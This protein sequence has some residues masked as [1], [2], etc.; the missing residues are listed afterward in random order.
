MDK[1]K[2]KIESGFGHIAGI[3]FDRS[4]WFLF[5][6]LILFAGLASGIQYTRLDTSTEGFLH[7]N[8]PVR[9]A[10]DA[11]K[12]QF[13]QDDRILV[14]IETED[15]FKPAFLSRLQQLHQRLEEQVPYLESVDS[16]ISSRI[17]TGDDESLMVEELFDPWP[18]HSHQFDRLKQLALDNPLLSNLVIN[19][20]STFTTILIQTQSYQE[21]EKSESSALDDL[22]SVTDDPITT[23]TDLIAA[24]EPISDLQKSII[25]DKIKE[26]VSHFE[27]DNFH[28]YVA[29]SPEVTDSLQSMMAKEMVLFVSLVIVIITLSLTIL[30]RR[31]VGVLLPLLTV[32]LAVVGTMGLMGHSSTP[33]QTVTQILPSFL[34][35]VGVGAAI[36]ILAIFFKVFDKSDGSRQDKRNALVYTL[37]HSGLAIAITSLTTAAGLISF[38]S[39][40][41]SAVS[42]LGIFASM[43]VLILLAFVLILIPALISLL[44]IRN[45]KSKTDDNPMSTDWIER[46]LLGISLFSVNYFRT[47][48][49]GTALLAL[50]GIAATSQISYSHNPLTWLPSD[51]SGRIATEVVD[52]QMQGSI[53]M[54]LII[55][56]GIENGMIQPDNLKA[57][58]DLAN[59]AMS[60]RGETYS[61]GKTVSIANVVKEIHQALNENDP[62][63]YIIPTDAKLIAQEVLLFENSGSDDLG[64]LV[65]S[66][67]SL[68][69]MTIKTP[70]VDAMEYDD[71]ITKLT[72]KGKSLFGENVTISA[73]GMIPML[74]KTTTSA[75]NS[76]GISYIIAFGAIASMMMVMLGSFRLGLISMIPNLLPVLSVLLLIWLLGLPLDLFTMLIG[77][78][79]IGLAVDDTVHFMHNLKRY[80]DEY[81][82][83][84]EAIKQTLTGTGRA[85]FVTTI[86]L[87][88]GFSIYFFSDMKNLMAFGLLTSFAI[89]M[90]LISDFLVAPALMVWLY[91]KDE[92]KQIR[93]SNHEI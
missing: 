78:I 61:V 92:D 87:S 93:G 5:L 55:D 49:F 1:I 39:S 60:L 31:V 11:F 71:L 28:I 86:V 15:I 74:V 30:F 29:G 19:R 33:I 88:A 10:Y 72:S 2:R 8:D 23:E 77:A 57:L 3:V 46:L 18:E 81:G 21:E 12:Q 44:P 35:A 53:S 89:I 62:A 91:G 7:S 59:Y 69:R 34:L 41:V 9:I 52:K 75:I 37:Q 24:Q 76:I 25:V 90:A 36:H 73:T 70:W 17:T 32:F 83:T 43:G 58:D 16:L 40:Q 54:E 26:V 84:A 79:V 48:L 6:M 56:S 85:M 67:F 27:G 20:D 42:R 65:D 63:F 51:N 50:G 47:I 4:I 68:A 82:N 66:Q 14:A 45:K 13:G 22:L 64:D 38:A 80:F